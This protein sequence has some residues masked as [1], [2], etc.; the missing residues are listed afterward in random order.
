VN[1]LIFDGTDDTATIPNRAVINNL[2]DFSFAFWIYPASMGTST[3]FVISK[4]YSSNNS[5]LL[6]WSGGANPYNLNWRCLNDTG[7]SITSTTTYINTTG[8]NRW[9]HI[10]VTFNRTTRFQALYIDGVSRVS[11]TAPAT[12]SANLAGG[13]ANLLINGGGGSAKWGGNFKDLRIYRSTLAQ[14]DIDK[15]YANADN[16]L[17]PDAWYKIDEGT[18]APKDTIT[19][20]ATITLTNGTTWIALAPQQWLGK[21]QRYL[22]SM[23]GRIQQVRTYLYSILKQISNPQSY[24]YGILQRSS[25]SQNYL[26]DLLARLSSPK[27]YRYGILSRLSTSKDYLYSILERMMSSQN[28]RYGILKRLSFS[29]G[30]LYSISNLISFTGTY[31]YNIIARVSLQSVFKYN[32]L[33]KTWILTD[34]PS[35]FT[36]KLEDMIKDFISSNWSITDP[37]IGLSPRITTS[38]VPQRQSQID[39]FAWDSFRSYYMRIKELGSDVAS[40]EIRQNVYQFDTP[41]EIQCY[42]RRL[43]KGEAF[44]ELNKMINELLRMFGTYERLNMFGIEGLSFD[45]I[46]NMDRERVLA[47]TIWSRK[48][49]II[50]HYYKANIVHQ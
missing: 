50:L 19:P 22:N 1:S 31:L 49:T 2:D 35:D 6:F 8:P 38:T 18:G 9:Y 11:G 13:V 4:N 44:H 39:N 40:N 45:R 14:S 27:I 26:Y 5:F 21:S 25:T 37:D 32:M 10:V 34:Q 30:Y 33:G 41:I 28:Y 16:A 3:P 7:S 24:Q 23:I 12:F 48:L 20:A 46:S 43:K 47:R 17:T 15:I 29:K 42:S 36:N